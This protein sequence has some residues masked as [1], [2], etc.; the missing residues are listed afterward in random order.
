MRTLYKDLLIAHNIESIDNCWFY[1][2][3]R[4]N[5]DIA[6]K[7]HLETIIF[8]TL[9]EILQI[10]SLYCQR[11]ALRALADLKHPNTQQAIDDYLAAHPDLRKKD[12]N[13][14]LAVT[15]ETLYDIRNASFEE[16]VEFLFDRE[17][18]E[19]HW[20]LDDVAFDALQSIKFYIQLFNEPAFLFD[21]FRREQ[22]EQGFWAIQGPNLDLAA[23]V[24]IA[25]KNIPLELRLEF[26]KSMYNLYRDFYSTDALVTSSHM[27]WDGVI[28]AYRFHARSGNRDEGAIIR[29]TMFETLSRILEL[30]SSEC[31]GAALH[32]LGHLH[33][34]DTERVI[35]AYLEAHPE[36]DEG[37]KSY[38]LACITGDI[39]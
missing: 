7:A 21:K 14:A 8:E 34:S 10:E 3:P 36:L 18:Y 38:A 12:R 22:L 11:S 16:F 17:P 25:D 5:L 20:E 35:K 37:W 28:S 19:G 31:K 29:N 2:R 6:E 15:Q 23:G 27:W 4:R 33:H 13:Y 39:M 26:I 30:D 24:L 1:L 32:G 9:S